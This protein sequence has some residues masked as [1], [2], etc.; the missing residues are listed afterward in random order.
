MV[1][2]RSINTRAGKRFLKKLA[3]GRTKFI[4]RAEF[5]RLKG[6]RSSS[7]RRKSSPR[8]KSRKVRK[9]VSRVKSTFKRRTSMAKSR[10]STKT[11]TSNKDL[12][13]GTGLTVLVNPLLGLAKK[14]LEARFPAMGENIL[15]GVRAVGGLVAAM[16]GKGV[17][18]ATGVQLLADGL[19]HFSEKAINRVSGFVQGGT[20]TPVTTTSSS[21]G[22]VFV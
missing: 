8:K 19:D 7:R 9:T 15:N 1:T 18:R 6:K 2:V 11:M 17:V 13:L 22:M 14:P 16:A 20:A 3:S 21:D 10:K 12:A 4:S 5:N